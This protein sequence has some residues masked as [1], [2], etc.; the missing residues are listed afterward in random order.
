MLS[1][2]IAGLKEELESL[3]QK[4][5][6]SIEGSFLRWFIYHNF[7]KDCHFTITDGN[8]DG[9]IDAI[10]EKLG[11]KPKIFV[12]QSKYCEDIFKNKTPSPLQVSLYTDFDSLPDIF[13]SKGKLTEYLKTVDS[14]LHDI[15]KDLS[16]KIQ[17]GWDVTWLFTT[18]HGRSKAGENRL[19]NIPLTNIAYAA[20]NIF[21][22]EL[23]LEGAEPP[24]EPMVLNFSESFTVDDPKFDIRTYVLKALLKDFV[25]YVD[26]DPN[27][28]ILARNVRS[29]LK[30]DINTSIRDTYEEN[31]E[32]FWYSHNGIIIVCQKATIT[33]KSIRLIVPSIINGAQTIFALKGVEKRSPKAYVLARIIEMPGAKESDNKTRSLLS[34]II[35]RAN[36]QNRMYMYDL[37]TNDPVQVKLA[38]EFLERRIFYERK[39]GQWDLNRRQLKNQGLK[40]LKMTK[41]AQILCS[42]DDRA[43]GASVAMRTLEKLFKDKT[44]EFIFEP[45]FAEV[46]LKYKLHEFL[47]DCL[48]NCYDKR[49]SSWTEAR[50]MIFTC[51]AT[52][53]NAI[54][55]TPKLALLEDSILEDP[56]MLSIESED[57][58]ELYAPLKQL[59]KDLWDEY[60]KER[61]KH[62]DLTAKNFF[63]SEAGTEQLI[64][65]Y[66]PRYEKVLL[67]GLSTATEIA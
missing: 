47:V 11:K 39:R 26:S 17:N 13:A 61:M 18:L 6:C 15:Y 44:Y 55:S 37:R 29:D 14:S 30:S 57:T 20:D 63:R 38:K 46:F 21:L 32:E 42:C 28:R 24:A 27:F 50:Q 36:Q 56:A 35:F 64:K 16:D 22:Y 2:S 7:E 48:Y 58:G 1:N 40:R 60:R 52:V 65:K 23:S 5:K 31:A 34:K 19:R 9:G 67:K 33:G 3:R 4:E 53:W 59:F 25:D 10:L 51:L 45:S 49:S 41:L 8:K 54:E 62:R 12:V 66:A 43:G